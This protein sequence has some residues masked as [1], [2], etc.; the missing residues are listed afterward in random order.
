MQLFEFAF[1][2][3]KLYKAQFGY[4]K[5]ISGDW[6]KILVLVFEFAFFFRQKLQKIKKRWQEKEQSPNMTDKIQPLDASYIGCLKNIYKK[7]LNREIF[8]GEVPDRLS[9]MTKIC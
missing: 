3:N 2:A 6:E 5:H 9:K 4:K 8:N 7:W 1:F